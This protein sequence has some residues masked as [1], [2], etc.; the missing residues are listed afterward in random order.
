M[1]K[2]FFILLF[3]FVSVETLF[4]NDTTSVKIFFERNEFKLSESEQK[5]LDD[6][7]PNDSSI[8]L[9]NIR[10]YGYCDSQE[11]DDAKHSLSLQ[12]AVEVKKYLIG[13]GINPSIITTV[14]GKGKK[15]IQATDEA[16]DKASQVLVV[17]EYEAI[18]QEEAPI[19]IQSTRKKKD[20]DE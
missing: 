3:S 20:N 2:L 11:K 1:K 19:I 9:K 8:I 4:A 15:V 12:R 17:I 7:N 18:A 6:V 5:I 13:K 16:T 14:E 10:I